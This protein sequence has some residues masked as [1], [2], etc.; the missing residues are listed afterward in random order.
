[1]R[2]EGIGVLNFTQHLLVLPDI[3][4]LCL[5]NNV[6]GGKDLENLCLLPNLRFLDVSNCEITSLANVPLYHLIRL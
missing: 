6:F 5:Q 2:L 3:Q 4:I 1:V